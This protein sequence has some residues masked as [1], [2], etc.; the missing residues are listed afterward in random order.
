VNVG[1]C[2]GNAPYGLTGNIWGRGGRKG[3]SF[4]LLRFCVKEDKN[5]FNG[6]QN[7]PQKYL[8]V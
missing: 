7:I 3:G 8:N 5:F 1:G 2:F 6:S 4:E